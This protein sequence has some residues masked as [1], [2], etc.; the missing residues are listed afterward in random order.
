MLSVMGSRSVETVVSI[1]SNSG[2]APPSLGLACSFLSGTGILLSA[3]SAQAA[4]I[5]SGVKNIS[6]PLPANFNQSGGVV[7]DNVT[8]E[9]F[10]F[11]WSFYE[12]GNPSVAGQPLVASLGSTTSVSGLGFAYSGKAG[13]NQ[14]VGLAS[15]YAFGDSIGAGNY[16]QS[17]FP[18]ALFNYNTSTQAYQGNWALGTTAFAGGRFDTGSG[19]RYGWLRIATPSTLNV[20]EPLTLV[21]WAFE[22]EVGTPILA[23]AGAV[24]S[25][26]PAPLPV[27]GATAAMAASR[28]LRRRIN[29][30]QASDSPSQATDQT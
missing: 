4:I 22:T 29:S 27:L 6:Y 26:A 10:A 8:G 20:G 17:P 3:S 24:S 9:Q 12:S 18:V 23:G 16:K 13:F 28:R 7:F 1:A 25:P 30:V 21:D 15:S 2:I 5:Y 11:G 19:Y 14:N